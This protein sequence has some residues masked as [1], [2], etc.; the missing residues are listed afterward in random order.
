MVSV[1]CSLKRG[2]SEHSRGRGDRGVRA[3]PRGGATR[4]KERKTL[5]VLVYLS[6]VLRLTS[7][8]VPFMSR[9]SFTS[10]ESYESYPPF[11]SSISNVR[12]QA[13]QADSATVPLAELLGPPEARVQ[14]LW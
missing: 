1:R 4:K 14:F 7:L 6:Q 13:G 5:V 3:R 12:I 9:I 2:C 11:L 8:I 10:R